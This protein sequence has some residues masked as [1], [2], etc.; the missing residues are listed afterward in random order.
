MI[1]DAPRRIAPGT[2]IG[3]YEIVGWLGAGG[4][5]DVYRARDPR[6]GREVAIKLIPETFA[7]DAN[8]LHRFEQEARAAG[9]L[10]H[11]NILAVH[12]VG[13]HGGAPYIVSE[14]LEGESLRGRLHGGPLPTRKAIDYARQIA[15]GLAAAHDK[16]IVHRDIKP[17]NLFITNAGRVKI[18]DF[19]IAKLSRSGDEAAHTGFPTET[20]AGMVVGTASYMSPEQVRGESVDPRS[21]I[22][23]FGTVLYEMLTGRSAFTRETA[24]ETMTAIL[25][26]DPASI[27]ADVSPALARIVS[28]CV[29]KTR[30][31]RFQS[32][33]DL[34]FGLE[35]LSD[36]SAAAATDPATS[37]TTRRRWRTALGV[38]VVVLSVLAAVASWLTRGTA[39]RPVENP[40]ANASFSRLTNW[41]GTEGAAEISPDGKF[42]AFIADKE[43][44][45]DIWLS[46]I[47]TDSFT[48]LTRDIP[49]LLGPRSDALLRR[50]GFSGDGTEIWSNFSGDDRARKMLMAMTGGA[51]RPFLEEGANAL[52]W[53][54]DGTHLVYLN[55]KNG[56]PLFVA[57]GKGG[58]ARQ[59]RTDGMN[60]KGMHNHNPVWSPDGQWI[61]FVHGED[62]TV[63]ADIFRIRASGG[64]PEQLTHQNAAVSL[65]APLDA[66]T[67]LYVAPADD[68]QG[69]W[70]WALDVAT[71]V[72]RRVSSGLERY[73]SVAASRD[74]RR[75]V[76]TVANPTVSL[77]R[78]PLRDREADDHDITP[79]QVPTDR[80]L[81]PR[82]G[83]TSLF[84][85][86][87]RG[88]GDGLWRVQD[89]QALEVW[90]GVNGALS[91]PPAVSRDG[92]HVAVVVRRAGKGYL[93]IMSADGTSPRT[94]AESVDV[95]GAAGQGSADWSPDGAWIVTGGNDV[96]GA[97][98][99]KIPVDGSAPVRLVSGRAVNPVWSPDDNLIVYVGAFVAGQG[100][101][102]GIRPNG[103]P[104][105]LPH[106]RV[107][108]G[109]YRFLPDGK[110]LVY[111]PNSGALDFWLLD[112]AAKTTR[113]LTRLSNQ[114]NLRN[115]DVTPDGKEIVFD[116]S[117]E[118][119]D[120]VL[121]DLPK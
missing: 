10:N 96:Q 6:L 68:R 33:R 8:R 19:G 58:D 31:M 90:K 2:K 51:R 109:G 47:G 78:V 22:F 88:T 21:D 121:I 102:L 12:D 67:L 59:I 83:G 66:R 63:A 46:Q 118:N 38:A 14:L 20:E 86:S 57:D 93:T 116:R 26:E 53:S 117:R 50:L 76:A 72:T 81:A 87:A 101:L 105:E 30:E 28:R 13:L 79:Y 4:M 95:Q 75:V 52:S 29:E 103:T 119:S 99:F 49:S 62:P 112:L 32:A 74:G 34:A 85:L 108:Q 104:V 107:R 64:A 70:L 92:A 94:L 40:L 56:D 17:D 77:W 35:V 7:T 100:E 73:T 89:G 80:A 18:L 25:K 23:S 113:Q 39:P 114:G 9:Q 11:P 36:T 15:E 97:A 16:S 106:L 71:R 48:N 84:Y 115:F 55:D 43:G 65:M 61:Y 110:S 111:L 24:P 54:A 1:P 37:V 98:L 5:G 69:P 3:P 91:E 42:V 44:Q 60:G 45:F 82:F 27:A 41:P 120:I